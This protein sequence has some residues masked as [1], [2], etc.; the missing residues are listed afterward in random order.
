MQICVSFYFHP[1]LHHCMNWINL[2]ILVHTVEL[3]A[4]RS[5]MSS[6]LFF[7]FFKVQKLQQPELYYNYRFKIF[8]FEASITSLNFYLKLQSNIVINANIS[9]TGLL[10]EVRSSILFHQKVKIPIQPNIQWLICYSQYI[11]I[12]HHNFGFYWQG[13]PMQNIAPDWMHWH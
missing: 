13:K 2:N 1:F 7:S 9:E 10:I 8:S 6:F 12:D 3:L 4:T 11:F 5:V